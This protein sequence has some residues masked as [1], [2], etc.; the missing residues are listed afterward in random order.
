MHQRPPF[1]IHF[2]KFSRGRSPRSPNGRG[3]PPPVPTP[4]RRFAARSFG[5]RPQL[6]PQ[7]KISESGPVYDRSNAVTEVFVL[8]TNKV[9]S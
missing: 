9:T 2:S 1:H 8:I 3:V 4:T 7:T 6:S 5:L